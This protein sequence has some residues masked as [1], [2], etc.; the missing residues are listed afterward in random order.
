M[1]GKAWGAL[2]AALMACGGSSSDDDGPS[3]GS[4]GGSPAA[5]P[6][7]SYVLTIQGNAFSPLRLEV[8]PGASV[9]VRNLDDMVHSVTS[10]STP[11]S[12]RPG[13]AN[14]I[15]FDTGLFAGER[16]LAIPANAPVGA[17]VSYYCASHLQTMVTPTG[18][19][20]IV[21]APAN[22]GGAPAAP[23]APGGDPGSPGP[24]ATE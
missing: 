20:A 1:R 7:D 5:N 23:S 12:F 21:T 19:I 14:G 2:L 3:G 6:D 13:A 15:S 24:Y 8:P 16:T 10:E 11:G 9:T 18:E 22:A 17:T 4:P